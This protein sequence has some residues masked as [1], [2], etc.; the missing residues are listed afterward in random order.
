MKQLI[1]TFA[2]L[3]LA[4]LANANESFYQCTLP[5]AEEYRVGVDINNNIAGF[6]DNDTTS[7]MKVKST[8]PSKANPENTVIVFE[9]KDL[10]GSGDLRLEFNTVTKRIRLSTLETDGTVEL[11]GFAACNPEQP[12][13]WS[14]EDLAAK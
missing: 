10:G 3:T 4:V 13:Q 14:T 7:I 8:R 1:L 9:G 5:Q 11:M 12:W 2:V 6:F